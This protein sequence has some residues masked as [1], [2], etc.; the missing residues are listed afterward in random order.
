MKY[1]L[2][3]ILLI[4]IF[5]FSQ[6][7]SPCGQNLILNS[8]FEDYDSNCQ[9][10][11]AG[12][13]FPPFYTG[14]MFFSSNCVD[15]WFDFDTTSPDLIN[16]EMNTPDCTVS[17][18]DE[19]NSAMLALVFDSAPSPG[20]P[21]LVIDETA[22]TKTEHTLGDND[23]I[24]NLKLDMGALQYSRNTPSAGI[25]FS[26]NLTHQDVI[27]NNGRLYVET[28]I[29]ELGA[30][31]RK[32]RPFFLSVDNSN[33]LVENQWT[34]DEYCTQFKLNEEAEYIAFSSVSLWE[35]PG[36]A[37]PVHI[38]VDNIV[39]DAEIDP[40]C[41][42]INTTNLG[43]GRYS[44][45][46]INDIIC[47]SSINFFETEF[48]WDF[49][50]GNTLQPPIEDDGWLVEHQYTSGGEYRVCV[51]IID[52]RGYCGEICIDLS[53]PCFGDAILSGSTDVQD[54]YNTLGV[55]SAGQIVPGTTVIVDG[56]FSVNEDFLDPGINFELTGGSGITVQQGILFDK[57]GGSIRDCGDRWNSV[58]VRNGATVD[59]RGVVIENGTI[60]INALDNSNVSITNGSHI[61]DC[62]WGIIING[63]AD[64][65]VNS[66]T[67]EDCTNIGIQIQNNSTLSFIGISQTNIPE[68]N[69]FINCSTGIDMR[70]SEAF[71]SSNTFNGSSSGIILS[72]ASTAVID[73]NIF[74]NTAS[75]G[76]TSQGGSTAICQNNTLGGFLDPIP[77]GIR[78]TGGTLTAAA[79]DIFTSAQAI[80]SNAQGQPVNIRNNDIILMGTQFAKIGIR[81]SG[82]NTDIIGNAIFD[83]QVV[84]LGQT[85][86]ITAS[87]YCTDNTNSSIIRNTL[88]NA[89][90]ADFGIY[91]GGSDGMS[92][93]SNNILGNNGSAL[94][95]SNTGNSDIECNNIEGTLYGAFITMNSN[96]N[97]LLGNVFSNSDLDL[98]L[99]SRLLMPQDFHG[100]IGWTRALAEG[101]TPAEI[102]DSRFLVED[103]NIWAPHQPGQ[104]A[105]PGIDW[106][107]ADLFRLQNGISTTCSA[108]SPDPESNP[109]SNPDPNPDPD[110]D[111][112]PTGPIYSERQEWIDAYK[113]IDREG[114]KPIENWTSEAIDL[115]NALQIDGLKELLQNRSELRMYFA[116]PS[117]TQSMRQKSDL[118]MDT[119]DFVTKKQLLDEIHIL[120]N[121]MNIEYKSIL[122][123]QLNN[124]ESIEWSDTFSS[125]HFNVYTSY[126]KTHLDVELS[127][128]EISYLTEVSSYCYE[129]YGDVVIWANDLMSLVDS[130]FE[131]IFNVTCDEIQTREADL[132]VSLSSE[133]TV[134]PNPVKDILT[135]DIGSNINENSNYSIY[136]PTGEKAI[137]NPI[138]D[139]ITQI[140]VSNL[141]AGVYYLH[142]TLDGESTFVDKVIK[143]D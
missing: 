103:L 66:S 65:S 38:L 111:T 67:L 92:I 42:T 88:N 77:R 116:D 22:A 27:T 100:N 114:E 78:S 45:R 8:D 69:N 53:V 58:L 39:L 94:M 13:N 79:N 5:S 137:V 12:N 32:E 140:D 143:T 4:P 89:T 25:S 57:Q 118:L 135:L 18:Q 21:L 3:G 108:P 134:Y 10:I 15:D 80:N 68:P 136:N 34:L 106:S 47:N 30:I 73:E 62:L 76:I 127:P 17:F 9:V 142:V 29:E 112:D 128:E 75:I 133:I 87:I 115:Y 122:E 84:G 102:D 35:G 61:L 120:T 19:I 55:T 85:Q 46:F 91:V 124:V 121:N 49:G 104:Q 119:D 52:H 139:R 72:S 126:L 123:R 28:Y 96:D 110:P 64:L 90:T 2:L 93:V 24:Y 86:F 51:S 130:E 74:E 56:N 81:T 41:Y 14:N 107:P 141:P 105:M 6:D 63:D 50:D 44:F 31:V 83:A 33:N 37:N 16:T 95:V 98:L 82:G 60:G 43:D 7:C 99:R 59:F 113:L 40:V 36:I 23:L 125:L 129:Y 11:P 101:L 70:N 20:N 109:E 132:D 131:P 71:I 97:E 1:L 54:L 48:S 26:C 138:I 117:I